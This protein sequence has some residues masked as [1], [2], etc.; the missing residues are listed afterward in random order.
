MTATVTPTV[1]K[2]PPEDYSQ[3]PPEGKWCQDNQV[4]QV[5]VE[6]FRYLDE[7]Q[8]FTPDPGYR[9]IIFMTTIRNM[10]LYEIM[11]NPTDLTLI[12]ANENEFS[13]AEEAG[14][15]TGR[16]GTAQVAPGRSESG[17]V[18]YE[19]PELNAPRLIRYQGSVVEKLIRI[20]LW[21]PP[22]DQ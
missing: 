15:I 2:T 8:D 21:D 11:V 18:M 4:R 3:V 1:E 14:E 10:G 9:F 19:V 17:L 22:T 12:A 13:L 7:L 16:L 5:C 6:D 20:D